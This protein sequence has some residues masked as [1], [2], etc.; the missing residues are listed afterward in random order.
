MACSVKVKPIFGERGHAMVVGKER[1]RRRLSCVIWLTY[2]FLDVSNEKTNHGHQR[3]GTESH[4][5]MVIVL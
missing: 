5:R 3:N 2:L 4:D 1:S